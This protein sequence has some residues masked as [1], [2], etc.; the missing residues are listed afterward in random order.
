M[1]KQRERL[2]KKLLDLGFAGTRSEAQAMIMEGL[3]FVSGERVDKAGAGVDED[4]VLEVKPQ[5]PRWVSRGAHKILKA[6]ETFPVKIEGKVCMDVGASTG[7]FT[8]VLLQR[9]ALVVYAID[10]GYGQLHWRLRQD[11]RARV[12]ERTNARYLTK[13]EFDPVPEIAVMDV[14]FISARLILP[15]LDGILA[16]GDSVI[17]LIKPQFEAGR[18]RIDKGGVVRSP[19]THRD[20]L[21]EV[22]AFLKD[23]TDLGLRGCTY[24][25]IKGPKGN[26]EFLFHMVKGAPQREIDMEE[27]VSEAHDRGLP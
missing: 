7:G 25:P 13:S 18:S 3:V 2:D 14:S 12:M 11:P 21:M 17:S 1:K 22:A 26:I 27:I 8:E 15:A 6:L 10:V 9:G 16:Q 4:A 23:E 24:S 19:E 5:K 20:I